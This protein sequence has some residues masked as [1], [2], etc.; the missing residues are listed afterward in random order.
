MIICRYHHS[1]YKL[2]RTY[3]KK[4]YLKGKSFGGTK[5][6]RKKKRKQKTRQAVWLSLF[7]RDVIN[8]STHGKKVLITKATSKGSAQSAH[9]PSLTRA[10]AVRRHVVETLRKVQ[11]K[12]A[13]SPN[14]GLRLHIWRTNK[15]WNQKEDIYRITKT[16]LF[17]YI[18]NFTTKKKGKFSDKNSDIFH[19]SAQNIDYGYSLEPSR[20]GGSNAYPQSMFWTEIRKIMYTP[21][22]PSF[23]T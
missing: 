23:T 18:E 2:K 5:Q 20:R 7:V 10:F 17:K 9:K 19:V 4:Y 11:A 1:I 13:C 22:N 6:N 3:L 15:P 21:V 8:R 16:C 14:R 12:N